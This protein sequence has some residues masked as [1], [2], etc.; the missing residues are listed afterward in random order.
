MSCNK[1]LE[2][3]WMPLTPAQNILVSIHMIN[4]SL[5]GTITGLDYWTGL[6][7]SLKLQIH[8]VQCRTEAKPTYSLSYFAN[9]VPYSVFPT[10]SRGQRMHAFLISFNNVSSSPVQ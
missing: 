8:L 4:D 9:T 2:N 6:L 1:L 3:V 10:V 5:G 7:D